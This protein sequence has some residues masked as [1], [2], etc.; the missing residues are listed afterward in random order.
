MLENRE[1]PWYR[2]RLMEWQAVSGKSKDIRR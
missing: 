1:I 2:L